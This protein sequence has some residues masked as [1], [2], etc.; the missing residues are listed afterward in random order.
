MSF[1]A[2][3]ANTACVAPLFPEVPWESLA[4]LL[5]EFQPKADRPLAE[6]A[7]Y[8]GLP[9]RADSTGHRDHLWKLDQAS[10]TIVPFKTTTVNVGNRPTIPDYL[11]ALPVGRHK[12]ARK[13]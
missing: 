13:K 6:P 9:A 4:F 11:F 12:K 2:P 10:V 5:W 8:P 1:S 7:V 3:A